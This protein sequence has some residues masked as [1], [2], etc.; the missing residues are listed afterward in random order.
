[1]SSI[2]LTILIAF[3]VVVIALALLGIS[4]LITGKLRIRPGACG[5]APSAKRDDSCGSGTSCTLC[6]KDKK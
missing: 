3:V 2:T 6:D 1:M 4:W 5:R